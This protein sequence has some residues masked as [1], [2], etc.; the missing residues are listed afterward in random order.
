MKTIQLYLQGLDQQSYEATEINSMREEQT[1]SWFTELFDCIEFIAA[2]P[3]VFAV[4]FTLSFPSHQ[5]DQ[6]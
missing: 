5:L 4:E 1:K 2:R 3:K 6:S